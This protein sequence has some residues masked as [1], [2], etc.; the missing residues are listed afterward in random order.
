MK[1]KIANLSKAFLIA[2]LTVA[3]PAGSAWATWRYQA[4]RA[5]AAAKTAQSRATAAGAASAESAKLIREAEGLLPSREYTKARQLAREAKELSETALQN[6][7]AKAEA[8]VGPAPK[9]AKAAE[10]SPS[11]KAPTGTAAP[12][13][14]SA[15]GPAAGSS[16]DAEKAIAAAELARKRAASAGGDWRDTGSIIKKAEAAA[17]SG[18]YT[19]AVRLADQARRQGDLGYEQAMHQQKATFP[20]YMK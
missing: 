1:T 3:V 13:Q 19:D 18:H 4:E 6:A 5:I 14:A 9:E 10:R 17:A 2:A 12:S 15:E 11:V 7:K 16:V 8:A 20:A